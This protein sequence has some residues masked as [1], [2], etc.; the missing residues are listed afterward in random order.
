M[1]IVSALTFLL[2]VLVAHALYGSYLALGV[3]PVFMLILFSFKRI[4]PGFFVHF[5]FYSLGY[6]W[7]LITLTYIFI[8]TLPTSLE[9]HTLILKGRV[10]TFPVH[11]PFGTHFIMSI[12][13][14]NTLKGVAVIKRGAIQVHAKTGQFVLGNTYQCT[15]MV[16]PQHGL[17]NPGSLNFQYTILAQGVRWQGHLLQCQLVETHFNVRE[18]I[19]ER[20]LSV[21]NAS[22]GTHAFAWLN[23]LIVGDRS[24]IPISDWAVLENTGTNHLLA[25]G[26]LH[27]GIIAGLSAG[28]TAW[29]WRRSTRLMLFMD[30]MRASAIMAWLASAGY[31]ILSGFSIATL[32]AFLMMSV[33]TFSLFFKY[34]LSVWQCFA[35]TLIMVLCFNP[36]MVLS[37]AFWFS[38]I[39][40]ALIILS[41]SARPYLSV[42]SRFWRV[43]YYLMLGLLPLSLYFF[44][45][46]PLL[47]VIINVIAIPWF[48]IMVLPACLFGVILLY[49]QP[50]MAHACLFFAEKCLSLLWF[51]LSL[52]S[53]QTIF[54]Y[55]HAIPN[56]MILVLTTLGVLLLISP[57]GTTGRCLGVVL[58]L[59]LLL[60]LKTPL[61]SG[62]IKLSV[63]DVGQGL[64]VVVETAHHVLVYDAGGHLTSNDDKGQE[65]VSPF[66]RYEGIKRIDTLM[67]SHGDNDHAGGADSVLN[68]F[69]TQM[70]F[71]SA[72]EKFLAY[73][74]LPC[75]AGLSFD[76]DAVH[77]RVLS[78]PV[79]TNMTGNNASCVLMITNAYHRILLPGDIEAPAEADLLSSGEDVRADILVAP[80]HG[81]ATSSTKRFIDA[82]APR[83]VIY[84][85]GYHNH[86][87]LPAKAI[88]QRYARLGVTALNTIDQGA[89]QF[90]VNKQL[91]LI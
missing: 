1:T 33:L 39:T 17:S 56:A 74:P 81:S 41:I 68:H 88:Q 13:S 55:H 90:K 42:F 84:S 22:S 52:C 63:L 8:P 30:V 2:G 80:H 79:K 24:R 82:V 19:R 9:N 18:K 78:P 6:V 50:L 28:L 53:Q 62:E 85:A 38:F 57:R 44:Q 86:Y 27:L 15:A 64:S 76:W 3:L 43:Q 75:H 48:G 87:G 69:P 29:C 40:I 58:I 20:L 31:A 16:Q 67:I 5:L 10:S 83:Y 14:L 65:I 66:L 35:T 47:S 61:K 91:M 71:T 45:T 72:P 59:P 36:L 49:V 26:G 70:L 77:F 32:R 37:S 12:E 4:I 54:I 23:A 11:N 89:I 7:T 46:A 25:I 60:T 21:M 34:R 51:L 73:H